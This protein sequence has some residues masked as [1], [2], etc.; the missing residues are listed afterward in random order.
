VADHQ[1]IIR[2][3]RNQIEEANKLGDEG[4]ADLLI[5]RIRA[6]EKAAW[7]LRSHFTE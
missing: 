1:E 3:L 5:Q 7:M 4:T 6:H 2:H